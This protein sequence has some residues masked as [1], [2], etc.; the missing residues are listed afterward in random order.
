MVEGDYV[1]YSGPHFKQGLYLYLR[2][3]SFYG[4]GSNT[5]YNRHNIK[6]IERIDSFY[7]IFEVDEQDIRLA[8]KTEILIFLKNETNL[9][10]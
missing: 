3:I 4:S 2:N 10:S 7:A 9:K 8:S 5:K 1:W 6:S